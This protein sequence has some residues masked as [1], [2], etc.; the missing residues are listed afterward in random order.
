MGLRPARSG[1]LAA[2]LLTSVL[3]AGCVSLTPATLPNRVL[4]TQ[5][6]N[7]WVADPVN[8]T[9]VEGGF[10]DKQAVEAFRDPADDDEGFP[11][12]VNVV[13]IRALLSPDRQELRERVESRLKEDA[14]AKGLQLE[15]Q[16]QEGNRRL[17]NG[18]Q[19]FYV[20]FNATS[21]T[22][23]GPFGANREV[24]ILGEV[25]RCTGGATVVVTGSAQT[26]G[27]RSIG[28]F[29][30]ERTYEPQTWAEIVRDPGGTI[31][32]FR[33]SRGLVYNVACGG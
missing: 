28:G 10:F 19:S 15:G 1:I 22:S 17:A 20:V 6:G 8:S 27:T 14:R 11:G 23:N 13:S 3:T 25:F 18:A 26:E 16:T 2:L 4:D 32:G 5:A 33:G 21:E 9:G 29:Q 12:F 31:E 24:K 30:T 7:G